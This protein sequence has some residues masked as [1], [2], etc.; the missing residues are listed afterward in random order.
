MRFVL[1]A[2][3]GSISNLQEHAQMQF[4][5]MHSRPRRPS[6]RFKI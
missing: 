1:M 4:A 3:M 2:E 5:F 6:H